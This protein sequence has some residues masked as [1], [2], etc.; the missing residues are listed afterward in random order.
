MRPVIGLK[1]SPESQN[2][3]K[4]TGGFCCCFAFIWGAN[5]LDVGTK[6]ERVGCNLT[7]TVQGSS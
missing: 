7:I 5:C 2:P 6:M 1:L 4:A 3:P